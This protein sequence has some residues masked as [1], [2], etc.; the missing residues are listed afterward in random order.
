VKLSSIRSA[1]RLVEEYSHYCEV[2]SA[3]GAVNDARISL[4]SKILAVA[5][6]YETLQTP[7]PTR[8]AFAAWTALEEIERGQ[9]TT[10][11]TEVVRALRASA[12]RERENVE[13]SSPT[14]ELA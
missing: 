1:L 13:R 4:G 9:G 14:A 11:A 6:A 2:V 7:T 8:Q 3:G 10:F 12:P 5:D